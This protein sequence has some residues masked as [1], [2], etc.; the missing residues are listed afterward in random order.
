MEIFGRIDKNGDRTLSKE[1]FTEGLKMLG[2]QASPGEISLIFAAL[3]SDGNGVIDYS[4][5]LSETNSI[6]TEP[7]ATLAEKQRALEYIL[8][9]QN[10][11]QT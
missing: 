7:E 11:K 8:L 1:E 2:F 4:E 9:S 5:V 3:D 6:L 10:P